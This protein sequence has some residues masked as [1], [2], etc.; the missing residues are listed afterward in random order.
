VIKG[1]GPV[2]VR[3]IEVRLE[4][5]ESI[6]EVDRVFQS[7]KGDEGEEGFLSGVASN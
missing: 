7:S 5:E 2:R 1:G 4:R 6:G 3:R